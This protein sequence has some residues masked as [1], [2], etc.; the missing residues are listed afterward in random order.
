M[1]D[2]VVVNYNDYSTTKDFIDA[3]I[4]YDI[5]SSLVVVDNYSKDDSYEKLTM[6]GH[7]K[8]T[9]LR[10]EKN[11]GYGYGNNLG[12]NY[13]SE[14]SKNKNILIANPDTLVS[15]DTLKV[16][17]DFLINNPEYALA[18]PLLHNPKGHATYRDVWPIISPMKYVLTFG[19][20]YSV[21]SKSIYY[22]KEQLLNKDIVDVECVSGSLLMGNREMMLEV[23]PYDENLFLYGEESLLGFRLK[24]KGY[25]SA[26][27]TK[28]GF[29]HNHSVSIN[30]AY[31]SII[32]RENIMVESKRYVTK[33]M[34][35]NP[36]IIGLSYMWSVIHLAEFVLIDLRDRIKFA[37]K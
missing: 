24:E 16:L 1:I 22:D 17:D 3:H 4:D 28:Y 2:V 14:Y 21:F 12:I 11:G 35:K 34:T 13:I 18:V 31:K 6:L 25:K 10:A 23:G 8:L 26:L 9:V 20:L 7:K 29:V 37:L 32:A 5:I 33:Q 27:L 36:I 15:Q 30:K 19:V